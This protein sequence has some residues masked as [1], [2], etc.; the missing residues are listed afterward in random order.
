VVKTNDN[1]DLSCLSS[2]AMEWISEGMLIT[3]AKAKILEVNSTMCEISGYQRNQIIGNNPR[4]FMSGYHNAEFYRKMWGELKKDG[5]WQ[6]RIWDRKK[7]GEVTPCLLRIRAIYNNSGEV[8]NYIGLIQDES[9]MLAIT[10]LAN[11]DPLTELPNRRLF[12][13]RLTQAALRSKRTRKSFALLYIDL[14]NFKPVNEARGH[15]TGD[16]VLKV[17]ADRLKESVRGED[18]VARLGGDEFVVIL[19]DIVN[20]SDVGVISDKISKNLEKYVVVDDHKFN[21]GC[22]IGHSVFPDETGYVTQLIHLADQRMYLAK[23]FK[24]KTPGMLCV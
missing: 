15:L 16:K 5:Q 11:K 2:K 7:S 10:E 20:L 22:S 6:G 14:D 13:E 9:K 23:N 17:V 12:D 21:I 19:A 8:T 24:R 18:T 3:D 4:M 1:S